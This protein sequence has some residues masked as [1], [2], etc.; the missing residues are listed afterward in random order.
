MTK[1]ENLDAQKNGPVTLEVHGV[2]LEAG[3]ESMAGKI[4]GTVAFEPG[5]KERVIDGQHGVN[6]GKYGRSK[7]A[8]QRYKDWDE[9]DGQKWRVD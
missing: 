7:K 1:I 2:S 9:A 3:R 6:R 5:V 8:S 4:C